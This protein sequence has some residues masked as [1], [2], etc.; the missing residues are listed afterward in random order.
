MWMLFL[1]QCI[2]QMTMCVCEREGWRGGERGLCVCNSQQQKWG[3]NDTVC[4]I[5]PLPCYF[6][7]FNLSSPL[8]HLS[9]PLI[10]THL[11]LLFWLRAI[12]PSHYLLFY[13]LSSGTPFPLP[14]SKTIHPA[15][16]LYP[17]ICSVIQSW[18][19]SAERW[20]MMFGRKTQGTQPAPLNIISN[21]VFKR[22]L[23][24][25]KTG[26]AFSSFLF[27]S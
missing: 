2:V 19:Q 4:F 14:Q 10:K 5:S 24:I 17:P 8:L 18:R 16:S 23:R 21:C 11:L 27:K 22:K 6:I 25:N 15:L 3:G 12:A 26:L 9:H 13:S 20:A 1:V 7:I